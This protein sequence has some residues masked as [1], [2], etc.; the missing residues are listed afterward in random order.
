MRDHRSVDH[1]LRSLQHSP[2]CRVRVLDELPGVSRNISQR[3]QRRRRASERRCMRFRCVSRCDG[4]VRFI[5]RRP[6]GLQVA[7]DVSRLGRPDLWRRVLGLVVWCDRRP[8]VRGIAGSA[9]VP[10]SH[11]TPTSDTSA[12][13]G[14]SAKRVAGCAPNACDARTLA[15]IGC[16][17]CSIL[18]DTPAD[19]STSLDEFHQGVRRVTAISTRPPLRRVRPA[20]AQSPVNE[21]GQRDGVDD[22]RRHAPFIRGGGGGRLGRPAIGGGQQ[23]GRKTRRAGGGWSR[24]GRP[25]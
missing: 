16:T 8:P 2:G 6:P 5:K 4:R 18:R 11:G 10:E 25:R 23:R 24:R 1:R 12:M 7:R 13:P 3:G 20:C 22:E 9:F 15:R 17:I 14:L 21:L 19:P